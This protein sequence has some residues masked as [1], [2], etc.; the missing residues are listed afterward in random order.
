MDRNLKT[1]LVVY[2]RLTTLDMG[3]PM[4]VLRETQEIG[5]LPLHRS[6]AEA[7]GLCEWVLHEFLVPAPKELE[8]SFM[9]SEV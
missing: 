5:A 2:M 6:P 7:Q 9:G 3:A 8:R 4:L 1:S